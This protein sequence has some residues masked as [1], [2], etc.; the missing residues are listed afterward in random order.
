MKIQ[1]RSLALSAQA[2][3]PH[4]FISARPLLWFDHPRVLFFQFMDNDE[5]ALQLLVLLNEEFTSMRWTVER[6]RESES[7]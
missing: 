4:Y 7:D 1:S 2:A 5:T 3:M 6:W